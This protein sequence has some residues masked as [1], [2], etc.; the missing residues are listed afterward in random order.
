MNRTQLTKLKLLT[1]LRARLHF[2]FM[3]MRNG[4]SSLVASMY[5]G[6]LLHHC[7]YGALQTLQVPQAEPPQY[8]LANI[9]INVSAP[10]GGIDNVSKQK[11]KYLMI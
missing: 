10:L 5:P 6:A 11:H 7:Y 3:L 4:F 1:L 8:A 9:M 2:I